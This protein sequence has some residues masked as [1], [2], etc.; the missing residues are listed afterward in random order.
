MT[1]LIYLIS[2]I[3]WV[4]FSRQRRRHVF[5]FGVECRLKNIETPTITSRLPLLEGLLTTL[6]GV[7]L[8]GIGFSSAIDIAVW[9][10]MDFAMVDVMAA[11]LAGGATMAYV[12]ARALMER[13]KAPE[14]EKKTMENGEWRM[15]N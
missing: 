3:L 9:G 11:T 12:G 13:W 5:E 8:F 2:I 6:L 10:G 14:E 4:I 1:L 15:E 7:Y